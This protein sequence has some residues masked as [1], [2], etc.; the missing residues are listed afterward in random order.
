[1]LANEAET[2][3]WDTLAG[4]PL[5]TKYP[6]AGLNLVFLVID[7]RQH[8]ERLIDMICGYLISTTAIPSLD[9]RHLGGISVISPPTDPLRIGE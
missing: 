4:A 6:P 8:K 9:G 5:S 7:D 2:P 3:G 1:M